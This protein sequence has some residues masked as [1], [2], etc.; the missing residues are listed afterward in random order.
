M[1]DFKTTSTVVGATEVTSPAGKSTCKEGLR[2]VVGNWRLLYLEMLSL[3]APC[4]N[5]PQTKG[6]K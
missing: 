2:L 1:G 3:L 6:I 5:I 4:L